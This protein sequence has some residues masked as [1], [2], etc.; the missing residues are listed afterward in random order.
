MG[1]TQYGTATITDF[2]CVLLGNGCVLSLFCQ[3]VAW[4]LTEMM[5][6]M[7]F[8]LQLDVDVMELQRIEFSIFPTLPDGFDERWRC[9]ER[10]MVV[11]VKK[12]LDRIA[13][14]GQLSVLL[15]DF[16]IDVDAGT[17]APDEFRTDGEQFVE[18]Q[19]REVVG[20]ELDDGGADAVFTI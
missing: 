15:D 1:K 13:C 14:S 19:W 7:S 4:H 16:I 6:F 3:M 11:G 2:S 8:M 10:R 12:H 17:V 18:N 5:T 20:M 9:N